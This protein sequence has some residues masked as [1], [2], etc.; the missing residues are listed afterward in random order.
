MVSLDEWLMLTL[1]AGT[2]FFHSLLNGLQ[3]YLSAT[4]MTKLGHNNPFLYAAYTCMHQL[5]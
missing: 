4:E 5:P 3:Q 2:F 1:C